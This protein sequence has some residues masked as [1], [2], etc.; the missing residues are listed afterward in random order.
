MT[1]ASPTQKPLLRVDVSDAAI[2]HEATVMIALLSG[3]ASRQLAAPP[4]MRQLEAPVEEAA[5]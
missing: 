3:Q 1:F 5:A 2:T 4:V